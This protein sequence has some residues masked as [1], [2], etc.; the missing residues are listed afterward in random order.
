[1]ARLQHPNIVQVH[2][3]GEHEGRPFFSLEF[4]G[5]GNLAQKLNGTPLAP[6]EAADTGRDA[7]AGDARRRMDNGSFIAT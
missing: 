2:E 1:M 3:V 6:G 7:G 4:C 5:G